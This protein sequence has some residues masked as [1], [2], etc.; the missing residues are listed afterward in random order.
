MKCWFFKQVK[1]LQQNCNFKTYF[2]HLWYISVKFRKFIFLQTILLNYVN[3]QINMFTGLSKTIYFPI[4]FYCLWLGLVYLISLHPESAL[5]QPVDSTRQLI[6]ENIEIVGNTKT[7]QNVIFRLLTISPGDVI[8]PA[9]VEENHRRL[10]QTNFFKEVDIYARPGS[11]KGKLVVV[12]EVKERRW[13]YF[14]FEGGHSDLN[15]WFFVPASLRFDNFFGRGNFMWV[16]WLLGDKISMLSLGYR[17]PNL[18]DNSAFLDIELFGADQR[19]IHYFTSDITSQAV[20]LGNERVTQKVNLGGLRTKIGGTEGILKYF[21]FSFRINTYTPDTT[22]SLSTNDSTITSFPSEIAN[23]LGKTKVNAFSV[24]IYADHR[25]NTIYPLNGFWGALSGELAHDEVGSDVN[26]PRITFDTRFYKQIFGRQVLALH[27]KGGYTTKKA[28]F[29]ERFYLGGANSLRGYPD[30]RLTPIGWG[31]KMILTSTE[32]RFP[33]SK[34]NFPFH[35]VSGI[36]FFDSGGIWQ[37]GQNPK[38][39]DLY[40]SAGF[41]FRVKL[42]VLG[43][44]RFDFSFPLNNVDNNDFQ[45]HISLGHTF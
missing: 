42:P 19:F 23:E 31:T 14:Q 15:G 26:F 16:R 27:V 18:F 5:S 7:K 35:K 1:L 30:R 37:P 33:I 39:D 43:I 29:Y 36:L 12:I 41:G 24:G 45:F 13:P 21:Y 25:D 11:E 9:L 4:K 17:N 6:V 44:T 38:L 22:A 28:P 32:Y 20:N 8:N 3:N 34:R 10:S 2:L 40:L